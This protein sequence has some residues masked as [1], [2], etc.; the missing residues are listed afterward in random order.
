MTG[1]RDV[2]RLA[3]VAPATVARVL[4]STA[5]VSEE[6]AKRVTEAATELE[7]R[8]NHIARSLRTRTTVTWAVVITDIHNPF[9]T[10]V[11]RRI[12]DVAPRR[13]PVARP[14]RQDKHSADGDR[15][16]SSASKMPGMRCTS[17]SWN[18]SATTARWPQPW[19][20]SK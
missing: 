3:G 13:I 12:E 15:L 16:R 7:Y 14:E 1:I 19:T 20:H 8:P 9:Y 18:V 4:D 17:P 11:V 2:A 5:E 10:S 6:L